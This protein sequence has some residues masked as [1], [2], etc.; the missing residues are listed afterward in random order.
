MR[1]LTYTETIRFTGTRKIVVKIAVDL[2][3]ILLFAF[4]SANWK[5]TLSSNPD[6][7]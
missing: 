5:R 2:D 6:S 1:V 7:A 3:I 4:L